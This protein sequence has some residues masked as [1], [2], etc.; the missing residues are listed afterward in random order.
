MTGD[1]KIHLKKPSPKPQLKE[2]IVKASLLYT[3]FWKSSNRING[4]I[5]IYTNLG[6][7]KEPQPEVHKQ[8]S[9]NHGLQWRRM[10]KANTLFSCSWALWKDPQS[11]GILRGYTETPIL[12]PMKTVD[13]CRLWKNWRVQF[14]VTK[15]HGRRVDEGGM[16]F[17]SILFCPQSPNWKKWDQKKRKNISWFC[18]KTLINKGESIPTSKIKDLGAQRLHFG[19]Y[20]S[21]TQ[22]L[23]SLSEEMCFQSRRHM[24]IQWKSTL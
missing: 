1:S 4:K 12:E 20:W 13:I 17:H 21:L 3:S 2:G 11:Y 19:P 7:S 15:C 6:K 8:K 16:Q 14:W 9:L 18:S 24:W 10:L 23:S 5:S 22:F